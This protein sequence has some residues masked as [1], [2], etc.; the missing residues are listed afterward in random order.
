[1][2]RLVISR[3]VPFVSLDVAVCA[4]IVGVLIGMWIM[5]MLAGHDEKV[6]R[7]RAEARVRMGFTPTNDERMQRDLM[8]TVLQQ[9]RERTG[10]IRRASARETMEGRRG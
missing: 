7:R 9:E 2:T 10:A 5:A 3:G 8:R 1:M 4:L 6:A